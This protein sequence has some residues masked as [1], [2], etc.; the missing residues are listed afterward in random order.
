MRL[1]WAR[2]GSAARE[3]CS[4]TS[5][6]ILPYVTI[7]LV[8]IVGTSVLA[9]DGGRLMSLQS[10]LQK[11]ADAL[12]IAG[13]AAG[14]PGG[15]VPTITVELQG[16]NFHFFFLGGL[17]GFGDIVI[18]SMRTTITGEDLSSNAPV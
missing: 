14:R 12:A 15:P 2:F 17:M 16:L 7:L 10:Q 6:V 9:L 5:G 13:A 18:P 11:G 8:V 4:D 3:F 1:M